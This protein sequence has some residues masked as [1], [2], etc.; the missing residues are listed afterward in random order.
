MLRVAG[1]GALPLPVTDWTCDRRPGDDALL[2]LCAG[3]VLDVGCGPGRLTAALHRSGGAA[4]GI[5]VAPV[6]VSLARA[7][8]ADALEL[9]V[10]GAVP[11][12]GAWGT[13]LLA[14]GNIGIGGDPAALLRR[15]AEL[16]APGGRVV[17]ELS[18]PTVRSRTHLV[19]L[20]RAGEAP[21]ANGSPGRTC[22][23]PTSARWRGRRARCRGR[24]PVHRGPVVRGSG[25]GRTT[26]GPGLVGAQH[27]RC[28]VSRLS[29]MPLP[30]PPDA[31]RVGPFREGSFR[32]RLHDE[33]VAARLGRV[34]GILFATCF[35]TGLFS[36][37]VQHPP[38]W[39]AY[40]S[41]PVDLYRW[42]QGL[43][44]L[45]GLASV[46]VLLAKLFTVYPRFFAW[47]PAK[48]VGNAVERGSLLLL[49][50]GSVSMLVT[51][52]MNIAG[53]YAF[54]F[55]FTVV[56]YWSA[57]ITIGALLVHIG[58]KLTAARRGLAAP[59]G[60]PTAVRA[61]CHGEVFWA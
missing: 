7:R 10:F 30:T 24:R 48:D 44:V 56:H 54:G 22:R 46:P 4:L 34:L 47:P 33:A 57:W 42:T 59:L 39:F 19:C 25:C 9:D 52:V 12:T 29:E 2:S 45:T 55:F 40:P 53:W 23:L 20:E 60:P 14:D 21:G 38:S 5:D 1:R 18:A 3:T 26:G 51:G 58:A 50:G 11:D 31:L 49:V 28:R 32:S 27:G 37:L 6:A 8:G 17:V 13:V 36:H 15:C 16:A 35:L 41:R 43:H 61:D